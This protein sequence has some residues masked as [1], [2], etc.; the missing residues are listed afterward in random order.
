MKSLAMVKDYE[1]TNP[2]KFNKELL[3]LRFQDDILEYLIDIAKA[4]ETIDGVRFISGKLETDESKFT[5]R[6]IG[7]GKNSGGRVNRSKEKQ[8]WKEI[9]D[10]RV[11]L[12]TLKFEISG[13]GE[14]QIIELPLNVPK[15][16]SDNSYY[17]NGNNYYAVFQLVDSSTYNNKDM[18]TLKSLLMPISVKRKSIEMEDMEGKAYKTSMFFTHLFKQKINLF[19][20]YFAK[21]GYYKT[22]EY[23][24]VD[25]SII[26]TENEPESFKS[27]T[28]YFMLN[29]NLYM[30]VSKK[31]FNNDNYFRHCVANI[32]DIL[33]DR[34]RMKLE[35]VNDEVG[36]YWRQRLGAIFTSNTSSQIAKADT[37]LASFNRIF[38]NCTKKSL[39]I[40][41]E[42]KQDIYSIIR[43]IIKNF[44]SLMKKDNYSLLTKRIRLS[45]YICSDF[46]KLLSNSTYRLLNSKNVTLSKKQ[47]LFSNIK[48]NIITRNA[49]QNELIRYNN[50]VNVADLFTSKLKY[51]SRGPQSQSE[52]GG[53]SVA[54]AYRG[55]HPSHIG[56][57]D[58]NSCSNTDPGMSGHFTPFVDIDGFYFKTNKAL[59]E[60]SEE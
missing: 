24:G 41:E 22:L 46:C 9:K 27:N 4:L 52:G 54:V 25:K 42:H 26:L 60:E 39:R 6:K 20:Y 34:A 11:N 1:K 7:K 13:D 53:K 37:V 29:K 3:D 44:N 17:L 48:R 49:I 10:S 40:D 21:M 16:T 23:F 19:Y 15:I 51:S 38:D 47:S 8:Y 58:L 31:R 35:N 30:K 5:P 57:L 28:I 14:R 12:V 33:Q 45:E 32:F 2:N 43:W 56:R 18:V 50:S 59:Q 55:I 36:T